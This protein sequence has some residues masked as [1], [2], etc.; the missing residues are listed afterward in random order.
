MKILRPKKMMRSLLAVFLA[1]T[2]GYATAGTTF[3]SFSY[4]YTWANGKKI[5]GSFEGVANG[6]LVTNL[7]NITLSVDAISYSAG[8]PLLNYRFD[9]QNP[10]IWSPGEAV[11]SFDGRQTNLLFTDSYS[12]YTNQGGIF[13]YAT[14]YLNPNLTSAS[15]LHIGGS[16]YFDSPDYVASRWS[17]QSVSPV[18]EPVSAVMLASGLGLLGLAVRRRAR[19]PHLR[20][21]V[22]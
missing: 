12:P 21:D 6:N 8:G 9:I 14:P 15:G 22:A 18:P 16:M 3:E 5:S 17:L 4:S 2:V 7:K 11:A 13:F 10:L 1:V 19:A 20:C